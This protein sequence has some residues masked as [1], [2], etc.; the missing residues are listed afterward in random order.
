M[1]DT[2][3]EKFGLRGKTCNFWKGFT[4]GRGISGLMCILVQFFSDLDKRI[5]VQKQKIYCLKIVLNVSPAYT[6]N[7]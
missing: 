5:G 3:N 4:C 6:L 7:I 1:N 2:R